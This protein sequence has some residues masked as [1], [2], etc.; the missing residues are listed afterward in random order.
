[1][2]WKEVVSTVAAA[3][4]SESPILANSTASYRRLP[5]PSSVTQFP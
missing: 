5:R 3:A 2:R 1:M 4:Q